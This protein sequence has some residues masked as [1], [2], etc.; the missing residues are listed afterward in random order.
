VP[1]YSIAAVAAALAV[2]RGDVRAVLVD[3]D[4][5]PLPGW[6]VTDVQRALDPHGE[7]TVP[8]LHIPGALHG[9]WLTLGPAEEDPRVV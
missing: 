7:R 8:E 3:V 5:D 1:D 6:A 9:E 4:E 2:D